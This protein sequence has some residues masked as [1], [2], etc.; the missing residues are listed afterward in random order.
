MVAKRT[1]ESWSGYSCTNALVVLCCIAMN[2]ESELK[3][4]EGVNVKRWANRFAFY[5]AFLSLCM[6]SPQGLRQA[7]TG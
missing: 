2:G 5:Q 4:Q 7:S 6:A 3:V 1:L